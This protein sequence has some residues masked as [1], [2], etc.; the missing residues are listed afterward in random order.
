MKELDTVVDVASVSDL[1]SPL[2]SRMM[3]LGE[4]TDTTVGNL[5]VALAQD[6]IESRILPGE[7]LNSIDLAA[8][9][10]VSR[11]PVREALMLLE[12]EGLVEIRPRRRP[13][14]T[15][16]VADRV[17]EV[18][19][20]RAELYAL[21]ARQAARAISP[22]D[23][24]RLRLILGLMEKS[25]ASQRTTSYFWYNVVFHEHLAAATRN[26][27]LKRAIDALGVMVLQLR[28]WNMRSAAH[29]KRSYMDHARLLLAIEDGD[30]ELAGAISR[31]LVLAGLRRLR[32]E[33]G[34]PLSGTL[35]LK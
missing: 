4:R 21:V 12:K 30:E 5:V 20:L 22:E 1:I 13:R 25:H 23:L 10:G 9:F 17:E 19:Q 18:Y 33:F 27:T 7:Q 35:A 24:E 32:E 8:R 14:A 28:N 11:T 15:P 6:I 31:T 29:R 2:L 34:N 16:I 26:R 3:A